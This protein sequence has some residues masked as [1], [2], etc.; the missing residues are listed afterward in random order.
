MS[1]I[2]ALN[3][4]RSELELVGLGAVADGESGSEVA[5]QVLHLLD[6]LQQLCVHRLLR[7]LQLLAPLALLRLAL[8]RLLQTVLR[9]V[10]QLVLGEAGALLEEGVVD[11]H[12][13]AL[14]GHLGRGGSLVGL[15]T[16]ENTPP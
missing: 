8:L 14:E 11:V 16:P 5:L 7:R 15:V 3:R 10:L 12:V 13:H 4:Y 9:S 1:Q 6:V 2:T